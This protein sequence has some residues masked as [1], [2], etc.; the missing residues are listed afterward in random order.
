MA[1]AGDYGKRFVQPSYLPGSR[2]EGRGT[3]GLTRGRWSH[4]SLTMKKAF[5]LIELLVVIAIVAILAAILFPV[6]AQAKLA[7]KGAA[8]I[9]NSKQIGMGGGLYSGDF[10][11]VEVLNGNTDGNAP[12]KLET[13]PYNS[14]G[15][16]LQP[17]AKSFSIF[18]DPLTLPEDTSKDGIGEKIWSYKT[19][20]AYAFT[21]HS[22]A[23]YYP[24]VARYVYSGHSNAALAKPAD[25]VLFVEKK[26]R[27]GNPDWYWQ[28][29]TIWGANTVNPP[30]CQS[31]YTPAGVQ[32]MSLCAP[33][34]L[35]GSDAPSYAGQTAEEGAQT[36][37]VAFRRIG[38]TVVTWADGHTSTVK[39]E[40][41]AAGTNWTPKTTAANVRVTDKERYVW[42]G[43]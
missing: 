6:F 14:W 10:D 26:A 36:A 20:F 28:G 15:L 7:A 29:S 24:Q 5:T 3:K 42:D 39:P 33:N 41:L 27:K 1:R 13:V 40:R 34:T 38:R 22:P 37:G 21:I 30:G 16:L 25:T 32:P 11:D 18:Q 31:A 8:A 2:N 17:Y 4:A 9:S 43:E 35:W 12:W 23:I 19:Q